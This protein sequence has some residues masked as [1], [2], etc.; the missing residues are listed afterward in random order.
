MKVWYSTVLYLYLYLIHIYA[1][2]H[3][4]QIRRSSEVQ[5]TW[6]VVEI[7]CQAIDP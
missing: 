6:K 1:S 3:K 5:S 4:Y 7:P 2:N